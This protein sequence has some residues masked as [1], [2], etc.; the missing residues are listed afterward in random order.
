MLPRPSPVAGEDN[1][2]G[3][4]VG[5]EDMWWQVP[6]KCQNASK[7]SRWEENLKKKKKKSQGQLH[8]RA[9]R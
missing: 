8:S 1:D 2:D 5:V 6:E 3:S 9:P 7:S 4:A